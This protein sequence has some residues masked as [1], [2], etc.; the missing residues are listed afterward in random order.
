MSVRAASQAARE[1]VSPT[2]LFLVS[3]ALAAELAL[4]VAYFGLTTAESTQIRYLLYPFVWINLGIAAVVLVPIPTATRR[5]RLL[6]STLTVGYF[7]LLSVTGG[8]VRL[9]SV[10]GAAGDGGVALLTSLPPGWGPVLVVQ[11]ELVSLSL[12]PY[13][14]VGY[15]ALAYLSYTA[16]LHAASAAAGGLFGLLSCVSCTWPVLAALLAN[17]VGSSSALAPAVFGLSIDLSTAAFVAA[18]VFLSWRPGSD[19]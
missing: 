4:L 10:T 9:G 19:T 2:G 5:R 11:T 6:A 16:L 13:R 1:W 12:V 14:L 15:L 18:V 8:L 17:V 3:A 7:L